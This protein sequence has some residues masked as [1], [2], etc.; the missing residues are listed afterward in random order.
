MSLSAWRMMVILAVDANTGEMLG[1]EQVIL[2]SGMA[3]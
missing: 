3:F 2:T 1:D